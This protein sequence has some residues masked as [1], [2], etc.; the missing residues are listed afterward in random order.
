[1]ALRSSKVVTVGVVGSG[2]DAGRGRLDQLRGCLG[3]KRYACIV[4][5]VQDHR[6]TFPCACFFLG[7]L[8]MHTVQSSGTN[9]R[10][11]RREI[12]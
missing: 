11:R 3:G 9:V 2:D 7:E 6:S 8:Q 10:R 4:M 1:M 5:Q 12:Q